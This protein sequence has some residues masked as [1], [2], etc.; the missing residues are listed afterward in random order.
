MRTLVPITLVLA[1]LL[2]GCGKSTAEPGQVRSEVLHRATA[3][4]DGTPYTHYPEGQPMLSLV[5]VSIP[6][7]TT[8][9]WHCHQTFTLG[10]LQEG[11]LEVET[12]GGK[13]I[14]LTAGDSLAEVVNDVHRGHT[15]DEPATVLMFH[16]GA[17]HLTFSQRE[18]QCQPP[19]V[20]RDEPMD[21]L[22]A[23]IQQRL[24]IAEEIA[25]HKWDTA[26]A[27]QAVARE[28]QVLTNV[29]HS[30]WR[31]QLA[32]ERAADFFADQIEANKMVQY[33]LIHQ[34][35]ARGAAPEVPRRDLYTTLR[36][37][38]DSLQDQLLKSL[39]KFENN[40][41]PDC[42]SQVMA[43]I[44]GKTLSPMLKQAMVRATG[45][46]CHND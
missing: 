42:A 1:A 30:A 43:R 9:D 39:A 5:K 11:K 36:P 24:A 12:T 23:Q 38:L 3:S 44:E 17:D 25:L 22:L 28:Q 10:Y 13:R 6:A 29:R 19:V 45:Q 16:A 14:R 2:A 15:A 27:V 4:W 41:R 21:T 37:Q 8:L 32:P 33:G 35:Q 7:N 18:A 34:W 26:Q 46:L 20:A 40:Y 31:Y